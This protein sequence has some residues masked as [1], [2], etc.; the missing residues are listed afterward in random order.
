MQCR[1]KRH[2]PWVQSDTPSFNPKSTTYSPVSLWNRSTT[3][4]CKGCA[5]VSNNVRAVH[6]A[7]SSDDYYE[8]KTNFRIDFR[9]TNGFPSEIRRVAQQYQMG[10]HFYFTAR[11]SS[12][13][14]REHKRKCL[15]VGF[16]SCHS[17][18]FHRVMSSVKMV[19]SSQDPAEPLTAAN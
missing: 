11:L 9:I 14:H 19:F 18:P 10:P 2:G 5:R 8:R 13:A 3:A 15:R 7:R 16:L 1:G 17:T 4:T 12:M 6:N